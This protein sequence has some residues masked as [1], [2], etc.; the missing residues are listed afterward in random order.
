MLGGN[1]LFSN[2][3]SDFMMEQSDEAGSGCPMF[4]FTAPI[5]NGFV[6]FLQ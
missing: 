3:I 6:R 5:N 2:A 1:F 4:D